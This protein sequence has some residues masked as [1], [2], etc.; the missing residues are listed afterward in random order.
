[1]TGFAGVYEIVVIASDGGQ[2]PLESTAFVTV[3]VQAPERPF[4]QLDIVWLSDS[5]EASL[6]ENTTLGAIVARVSLTPA[7]NS[8]S[9]T[10]V[11]VLFERLSLSG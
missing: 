4:P 11:S 8:L 9:V 3:T 7:D 6:H 10:S 5:G 1:M 2:P